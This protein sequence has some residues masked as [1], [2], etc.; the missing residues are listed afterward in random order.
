M[1]KFVIHIS[2]PGCSGKSTLS[3]ALGEKFPGMYA[4][5]Y[6]KLKWQLSGYKGSGNNGD[7]KHSELINKIQLGLF[8]V[9][10]KQSVPINL[11][12][13]LETEADYIACKKIAG[14]NGYLLIPV[15]LTAPKEVLL[16]RFNDRV[17]SAKREGTKISITDKNAFLKTF[18]WKT[19]TPSD[20]LIFDTS[21]NSPKDIVEVISQKVQ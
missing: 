14:N 7:E 4:V 12:Y 21:K 9:V 8:E 18:S 20:A 5:A 3:K 17:E 15:K 1:K 11:D 19:F 16:A 2:G 6:D 13:F 10:C